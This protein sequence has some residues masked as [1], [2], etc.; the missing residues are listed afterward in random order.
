MKQECDNAT[1]KGRSTIF[2][3]LRQKIV[4]L[5]PEEGV[6][7]GFIRYLIDALGYPSGLM[8][9]EYSIRIGRLERRCDTVIFGDDL[10]PLMIVEYKAPHIALTQEVIDQVFRYNSVLSVP[11]IV[12]TNGVQIGIF[13]IGYGGA[14]TTQ[15]SAL[16]PYSELSSK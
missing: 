8:A 6:R 7:Q 16:P 12:I 5:T 10:S 11:Y 15:L 14:Q 3:P 1:N 2:D 9:N 4:A 13:R